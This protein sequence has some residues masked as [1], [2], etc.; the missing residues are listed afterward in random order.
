[1]VNL[2]KRPRPV[3]VSDDEDE[4]VKAPSPKKI[5]TPSKKFL[6]GPLNDAKFWVEGTLILEKEITS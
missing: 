3:V 1:M 4:D 5:A 2:G 6:T